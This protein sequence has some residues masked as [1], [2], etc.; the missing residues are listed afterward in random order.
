MTKVRYK[1]RKEQ[2]ERVVENFVMES[3]MIEKNAA[4]KHKMSMGAEQADDM[5]EGMEKAKEV[6]KAKMKQAPE[7]KKHIH[8]KVN[9]SRV[10]R[11]NSEEEAMEFLNDLKENDPEAYAKL[12]Q[13]AKS[14][15]AKLESGMQEEGL[16]DTFNRIKGKI[17]GVLSTIG[18]GGLGVFGSSL[19]QAAKMGNYAVDLT[20]PLFVTSVIALLTG[21]GL[22][23]SKIHQTTKAQEKER[24]ERAKAKLKNRNI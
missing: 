15:Q 4:K 6:K 11:E 3:A 22:V 21:G 24:M 23:A 14:I 10:L 8:G 19:E 9:E 17:G 2:L 12:E 7:V 13:S 18:I 5:G 16:R 1:I 20:D